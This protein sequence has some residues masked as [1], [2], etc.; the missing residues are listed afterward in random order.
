ATKYAVEDGK[1]IGF[2]H[3]ASGSDNKSSVN[4]SLKF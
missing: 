2:E 4:F 3:R 1:S